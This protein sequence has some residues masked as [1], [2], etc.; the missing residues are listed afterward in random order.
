MDCRNV[1]I[2]DDDDV[3]L[4]LIASALSDQG[5]SVHTARSSAEALAALAA[6]QVDL[7]LS[8]I[9]MPGK[10]GIDLL[11]QLRSSGSDVPVAFIT[12]YDSNDALLSAIRLGAC[13]FIQKPFNPEELLRMVFRNVEAGRLRRELEAFVASRIEPLSEYQRRKKQIALLQVANC[14]LR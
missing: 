4:S 13:D 6:N 3:M 7:I 14:K 11:C 2:V 1:L 10:S 8:D 9:S 12:G 5:V